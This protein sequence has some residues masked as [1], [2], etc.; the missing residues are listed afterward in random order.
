MHFIAIDCIPCNI[1]Y[2]PDTNRSFFIAM[3]KYEK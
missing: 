2:T 3:G 1:A